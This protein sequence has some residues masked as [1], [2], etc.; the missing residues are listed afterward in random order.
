[1]ATYYVRPDGNNS[2][3]GTGPA[4]NQAWATIAYALSSSSGFTSGDTLYVA[5]G[6]YTTQISITMSNPTTETLII[7]DPKCLVFSGVTA[8]PIVVTNYNSTL[9]GSGYIGNVIAATT[10]NFLHFQ[11]IQFKVQGNGLSFTT[12]INLKFTRCHFISRA[13][14]GTLLA[15]TSPVS[16]AVNLSVNNCIFYGADVQINITGRNVSDTSVISNC[17]FLISRNSVMSLT[18]VQVAV[19]NCTILGRNAGIQSISGSVTFPVTVRNCISR[20]DIDLSCSGVN[21]TIIENNN[22]LL[23]ELARQ[24]VTDNGTSSINGDLGFEVGETLLVG[25]NNLQPFTSYFGSPNTNFGNSTGAPI[26]DIYGVTWTGVN[27]DAG[28]GTYRAI[29]TIGNYNPT[30]RNASTITIAPGSLS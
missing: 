9:S 19:S 7:G 17:L 27:P 5:P 13:V 10:K 22:R 14:T 29:G 25:L 21:N 15:V 18:G 16:T 3:A 20:C 28:S 24:N 30:E 6:I 1:M 8:G 26:S 2:N 4:I 11:N 12:C 23:G